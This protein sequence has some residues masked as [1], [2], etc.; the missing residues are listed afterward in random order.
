MQFVN[1]FQSVSEL[2]YRN[3]K[4]TPYTTP[5]VFTSTVRSTSVMALLGTLTAK[6]CRS[7]LFKPFKGLLRPSWIQGCI[8]GKRNKRKTDSD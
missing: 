5:S 1:N 4:T 7:L 8:G 6:C 2:T 3:S